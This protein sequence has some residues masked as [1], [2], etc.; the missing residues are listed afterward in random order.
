[1]KDGLKS[2]QKM[3][4]RYVCTHM[5]KNDQVG[6]FIWKAICR[7]FLISKGFKSRFILEI[8]PLNILGIIIFSIFGCS[9][10]NKSQKSNDK[11]L[12]KVQETV[13]SGIFL[14]FSS[15]KYHFTEKRFYQIL[16]ITILGLC[17]KFQR[18][19]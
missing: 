12:I 14:V 1:M 17:A 2:K 11:I 6:W 4:F 16:G 18:K 9:L 15:G 3:N 8:Q 13:I 5:G 19:I 10:G 7:L